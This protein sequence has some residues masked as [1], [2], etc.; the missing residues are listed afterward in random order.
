MKKIAL[1]LVV[2]LMTLGCTEEVPAQAQPEVTKPAVQEE[3]KPQEPVQETKKDS[4]VKKTKCIMVWDAK[5]QKEV[6]KCRTLNI[7]QKHDGTQV[8]K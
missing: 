6:K 7:H 1:A 8:P 4:P 3:V 2:A 5:Q